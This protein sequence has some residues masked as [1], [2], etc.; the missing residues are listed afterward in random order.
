MAGV[1][2]DIPRPAPDH[3]SIAARIGFAALETALYLPVKRFLETLGFD[4]KGEVGGCDV[5]AIKDGEPPVV[6]I[7]ELKMGFNLEL[8]L[9]GVDRAAAADEIWLAAPLSKRGKGREG[10]ARFRNLCRRLGFGL[11]GV[12]AAGAVEILVPAAAPQPRRDAKRRSRLVDEHRRRK[13]DPQAGGGAGKPVMTAYRQQA[14]R[15]AA[16]LE[17]GP[18]RPRDLAPEIPKARDVLAANV[19][20]WFERVDRGVYGLTAAGREALSRWPQ[21][22]PGA[23]IA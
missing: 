3:R 14:L 15:L 21:P 23:A 6:V 16:C 17:A 12:T 8:V 22:A 19:Y 18:R 13:G 10:D 9:Q 7:G 4:V 5:L 11:L 20:G 2:V 1:A